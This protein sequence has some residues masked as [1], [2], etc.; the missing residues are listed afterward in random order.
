MAAMLV[1]VKTFKDPFDGDLV[2]AGRTYVHPSCEVALR[3]PR[4]F[5]PARDRT[6]Q[7]VRS[8][9]SRPRTKRPAWLLETEA[10]PWKL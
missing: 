8:R 4:N 10:S 7:L 2:E 9:R 3:F 6:P 5:R 1:A